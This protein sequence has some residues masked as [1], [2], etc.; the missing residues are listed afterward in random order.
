[1]HPVEHLLYFSGVLIHWIVPS[2]P[3]HARFQLLHAGLSPAQGHTGFDK[4]VVGREASVDFDCYAH[5]LHHKY[6]EVNYADGAVP[7]RRA[8]QGREQPSTP[9]ERSLF[10]LGTFV[11][12][13]GR[14]TAPGRP[15]RPCGHSRLLYTR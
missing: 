2:H 3:I 8:L 6:F 1:M 10:A 12:A 13:K 14:T 11:A 4:I 7:L 9:R 5:Y 15:F